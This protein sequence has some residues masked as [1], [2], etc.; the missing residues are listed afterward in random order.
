MMAEGASSLDACIPQS[1]RILQPIQSPTTLPRIAPL[2]L[3]PHPL[4]SSSFSQFLLSFPPRSPFLRTN[5]CMQLLGTRIP[6]SHPHSVPFFF[7]PLSQS[8]TLCTDIG[9]HGIFCPVFLSHF[10]ATACSAPLFYIFLHPFLWQTVSPDNMFREIPTLRRA[11]RH[12]VDALPSLLTSLYIN[13]SNRR[14]HI[15]QPRQ[16][17]HYPPS[18]CSLIYVS[19]SDDD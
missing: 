3:H 13:L 17:L 7:P 5:S 8:L 9:R 11:A 16:P 4:P 10:I 2:S 18:W 15:L 12:D 19:I 14:N 1:I 6:K